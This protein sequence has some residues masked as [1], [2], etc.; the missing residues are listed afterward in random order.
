MN[1]SPL[2][3]LLSHIQSFVRF[4]T[5]SHVGQIQLAVLA[6]MAEKEILGTS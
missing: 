2:A 1:Q 3:A 4:V 6:N 5:F